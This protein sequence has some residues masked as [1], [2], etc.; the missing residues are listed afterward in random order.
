MKAF[1]HEVRAEPD[2]VLR[3]LGLP[4]RLQQPHEYANETRQKR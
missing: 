2:V 3:S 4:S 1:T